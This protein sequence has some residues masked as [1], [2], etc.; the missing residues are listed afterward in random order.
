MG[1]LISPVSNTSTVQAFT[2]AQ[3]TSRELGHMDF[4]VREAINV[5]FVQRMHACT[6]VFSPACVV[7]GG[8]FSGSAAGASC[9]TVADWDCFR[10]L[11]NSSC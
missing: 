4:S 2:A 9:A 10:L 11:T 1:G 8:G 5:I 6:C 7:I 3:R